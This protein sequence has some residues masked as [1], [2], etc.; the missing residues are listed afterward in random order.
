[1]TFEQSRWKRRDVRCA[2]PRLE[3]R[4]KILNLLF[5]PPDPDGGTLIKGL[6]RPPDPDGDRGLLRPPDPDG[7]P[8]R[9]LAQTTSS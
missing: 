1:M 4:L 8:D 5:R 3:P 7:V 2:P 9:G 6:L